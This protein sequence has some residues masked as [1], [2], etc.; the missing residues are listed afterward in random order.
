MIRS[1]ELEHLSLIQKRLEILVGGR[2]IERDKTVEAAECIDRL[3]RK[4]KGWDSAKE[5]RRWRN[6]R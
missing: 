4:A 2:I 5:V 1:K 6:R 3:R